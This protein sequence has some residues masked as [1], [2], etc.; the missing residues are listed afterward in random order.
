MSADAFYE[1]DGDDLVPTELT[2]GPW[3]AAAQHAGPPAALIGRAVERLAARHPEPTRV[4]RITYEIMRPVPISPVR[5]EA[6]AP[7]T[8]GGPPT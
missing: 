1:A 5:V 8:I 4:G 2:R 6:G 3:D 7:P